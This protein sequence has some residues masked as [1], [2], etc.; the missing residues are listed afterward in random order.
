MKKLALATACA[1]LA[2]GSA[3]LGTAA[4]AGSSRPTVDDT[5]TAGHVAL[6]FDDGPS[7]FRPQTLEIL[8]EELVPATFLDIGMRVAANPHISAFQVREGHTV[9]NHTYW[10][11]NLGQLSAEDVR[12]EILATEIAFRDARVRMP[13]DGVRAPFGGSSPTSEQAI[14]DLGY[15]NV[16]ADAG[17]FDFIPTTPAATIRDA[18]LDNLEDGAILLMHDG[19]IDTP[20]GGAV[21][22]ALPQVIDGVREQGYCFGSVDADGDVVPDRLRPTGQPIP[23]IENPVPFR[24]IAFAGTPPLA[25]P[26]PYAVVE[27]DPVRHLSVDVADHVA[28]GALDRGLANRI[29]RLVDDGEEAQLRGDVTHQWVVLN[30]IE[31]VVTSAPARKIDDAARE[32][33]LT[34]IG[35]LLDSLD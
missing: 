29:E 31:Q 26:E 21:I 11:D 7:S 8:R 30:R 28:E 15:V 9:L 17:G 19:P 10:H 1:V 14:A 13:Y 2:A 35:G 5:C 6:T 27:G 20:A 33:L 25:P 4:A 22:E 24:P 16:G 23:T 12:R 34:E 32:Q 3:V 18:I